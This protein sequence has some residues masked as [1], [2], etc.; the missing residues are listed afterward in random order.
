MKKYKSKIHYREPFK[1]PYIELKKRWR[2]Y[3][4]PSKLGKN[5][6]TLT[7]TREHVITKIR[8]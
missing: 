2:F 8:Y 3:T 4:F 1:R 7:W 5:Q 6:V